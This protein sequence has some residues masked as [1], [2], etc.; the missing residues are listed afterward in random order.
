MAQ[1]LRIPALNL[2]LEP[3]IFPSQDIEIQP[4]NYAPT[5][6]SDFSLKYLKGCH[7]TR[8]NTEHER[9]SGLEEILERFIRDIDYEN[10]RVDYLLPEDQS[11]NP[12]TI[13]INRLTKNYDITYFDDRTKECELTCILPFRASVDRPDAIARV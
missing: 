5:G 9:I 10:P 11:V 3:W 7:Y 1:N 2:E 12:E 13:D 4:D 8:R 6:G